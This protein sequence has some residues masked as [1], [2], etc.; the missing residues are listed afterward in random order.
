[1][2]SRASVGVLSVDGGAAANSSLMQ[3]QADLSGTSVLRP[4]A[5]DLSALGAA[6]LAGLAAGLWSLDDLDALPR[7]RDEFMPATSADWRDAEL[8]LW[9]A[10][11]RRTRYHPEREDP[12]EEP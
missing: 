10:A 9:R 2:A 4:K 3:L 8:A 5:T 7:L 12:K 6:Q 11:I 1:M